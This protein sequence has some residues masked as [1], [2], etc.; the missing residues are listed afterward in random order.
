MGKLSSHRVLVFGIL[1]PFAALFLYTL[2]YSLLTQFS[3][4]LEKDWRFRL[5]FSTLAM[6]VPFFVTL[7][8]A[9]KAYRRRALS[10]SGKI[11]VAIAFLSLAL[12]CKPLGD[13]VARFKQSRNLALRDVAAPLFDTP[14]I[15]GKPQRLADHRG[16][17]VL[18]NIWATWCEPCRNEMPKLEL[19]YQRR[20]Q[21][22]FTVFGMSDESVEVQRKFLQQ[23]P[24]SYPLLTLQG[25][26][27]GLYRDI[28]RY[29]AIFLIDRQG[30]LQP[31]P[32][33]D[34]PFDKMEAAVDALLSKGPG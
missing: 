13:G 15:S 6:T 31:A 26:V 16:E 4:D 14:D 29:P 30:R 5:S 24:V 2:V 11:G 9:I 3:A 18:V 25:E 21:H 1:S 34:Q 7:F 8:M 23:I 22:G 20:R 27:P 12:V 33:P 19:L 28:A 10:L 32:G 17:V